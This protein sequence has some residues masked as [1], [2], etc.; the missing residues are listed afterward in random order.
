MTYS[1]ISCV[2]AYSYSKKKKFAAAHSTS[3]AHLPNDSI[4]SSISCD[5]NTYVNRK[6]NSAIAALNTAN[7]IIHASTLFLR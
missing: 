7:F 1:S 5:T 6:K 4:P 3:I 2:S